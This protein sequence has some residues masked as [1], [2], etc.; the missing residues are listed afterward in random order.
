VNFVKILLRV[1]KISESSDCKE[2]IE[3]KI[4]QEIQETEDLQEQM[5]KMD[6]NL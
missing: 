5:Y 4:K 1:V 3:L 6:D 2:I